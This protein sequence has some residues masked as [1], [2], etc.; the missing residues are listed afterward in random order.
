MAKRIVALLAAMLLG[1]TGAVAASTPAGASWNA[2]PDYH[3]CM[4]ANTNYWGATHFA[5]NPAHNV[6]F[7]SET[8]VSSIR[9]RLRYHVLIYSTDSCSGTPFDVYPGQSFS[10]MPGQIGDNRMRRFKVI[11]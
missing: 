3:F 1:L 4:W 7:L 2:C 10:P 9:N 6:C 8:W 11:G 5:Q